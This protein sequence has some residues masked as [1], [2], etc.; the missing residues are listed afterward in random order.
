M[1]K[2]VFL[3]TVALSSMAFA[4]VRDEVMVTSKNEIREFIKDPH[5]FIYNS[6]ATAYLVRDSTA[7]DSMDADLMQY[8]TSNFHL[9]R[10]NT[11]STI[12]SLR[13]DLSEFNKRDDDSRIFV[14]FKYTNDNTSQRYVT[15]ADGRFFD[16]YLREQQ[17]TIK[18]FNACKAYHNGHPLA[19]D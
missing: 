13:I 11:G 18:D 6:A 2:L 19:C 8:L 14:I 10:V 5:T 3:V 9:S 15:F 17:G 16:K 12:K 1:K 7:S 4:E